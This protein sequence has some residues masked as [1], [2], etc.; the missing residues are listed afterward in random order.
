MSG[1]D[2]SKWDKLSDSSASDNDDNDNNYDNN[3]GKVTGDPRVTQLQYPSRVTIGPDGIHMET[4]PPKATVSPFGKTNATTTTTVPVQSSAIKTSQD[5][6]KNE[7]EEEDEM[8]YFNLTRNGGCEGDSHLWSQTRDTA[9]VSFI[10]P[11][12]ETKAKDICNFR[13]IAEEQQ[14]RTSVC[15]LS[16]SL[17]GIEGERRYVFRYP[18]KV[19]EDIVDGCWQLHSLPTRSLRLLIVQLVKEPVAMGMSLWWDKCFVTD[20]TVI[21]TRKIADRNN[22]AAA[23][24]E[25]FKK[26][27]DQAHEEFKK[28]ID[29]RQQKPII[30]DNEEEEEG[31]G[32]EDGKR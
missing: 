2:Y 14:D 18:V 5:V 6:Y 22:G 27:W 21:D 20:Q 30:I 12:M 26:V 17:R 25:E 4:M 16:F 9:T 32:E 1:I 23:R 31:E 24:A 7:Q 29:E 13:L 28:R 3:E 15:V 11:T 19:D 10:L 8:M